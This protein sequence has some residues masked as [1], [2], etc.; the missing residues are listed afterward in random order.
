MSIYVKSGTSSATQIAG[1]YITESGGNQLSFG[2]Y[3]TS[4][5]N[6]SLR[7]YI[8]DSYFASI[9]ICPSHHVVFNWN[10]NNLQLYVDGNYIKNL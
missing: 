10:G 9:C 2:R 6:Q 4:T 5:T 1:K 7:A 8:N 3:Y